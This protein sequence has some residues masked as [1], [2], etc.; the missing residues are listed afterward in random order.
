MVRNLRARR[1][2]AVAV[3]FDAVDICCWAR[4]PRYHIVWTLDAELNRTAQF[5]IGMNMQN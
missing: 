5:C 4:E 3:A 2:N 1:Q